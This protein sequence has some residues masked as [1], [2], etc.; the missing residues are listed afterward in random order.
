MVLWSDI[1]LDRIEIVPGAK[2][3]SKFLYEGGPLRF[4]IPRAKSTWGLSAYKSMNVDFE[5]RPDFIQWWKNL[6]T[7]LCPQ[8]PFS[9][10]LK[11]TMSLRVKMDEATYIFDENSKQISPDIQEGL[12]RGLDL[13]CIVDVDSTYFFNEN[14]GLTVRTYQVRFSGSLF[15]E[16]PQPV[17]PKGACAFI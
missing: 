12:F 10:N 2:G 7:H 16:E 14:W 5:D 13:Q 8:E 3:R 15:E 17:L 6:E 9:S 1:D 11:S 4:Q